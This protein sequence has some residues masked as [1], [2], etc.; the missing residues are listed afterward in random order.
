MQCNHAVKSALVISVLL[1]LSC[2]VVAQQAPTRAITEIADDL[3]WAQNNNHHSVFLVT[4]EGI[5]L[6]DPINADFS[7]W[8]KAELDD[9]FGVPVRYVVYSHHHW[10]HASGGAVFEDTAQFIGHKNMLGNL[11]LLPANTPLPADAA[12]LDANGNGQIEPAEASGNYEQSFSLYDANGDGM[13]SGAEATRGPLNEVRAPDVVYQ[14]RMTIVLGGKS[15]DL[16]HIGTI[17]HTDDMSVVLFPGER[18]V[19][20][21]DYISLG[22]L[23]F[24]TIF[25][26]SGA[27]TLDALL[28]SMRLVE[29]LDFD[30]A[31]PGHGVVGDKSDIA[32]YRHYLEELRDA[33][34]AG[35][36]AGRSVEE[37]QQSILMDPYRDWIAYEAW[38]PLNVVGMYNLLTED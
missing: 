29:M 10:D 7:A 34:A 22:R 11:A 19:F 20:F 3:Y 17:D 31:A 33:V 12:E 2:G 16:I 4:D 24:Q 21:V 23:P 30:V 1:P 5:I 27:G 36:A 8:L 25:R 18:A 32:A 35:I 26:G 38:R 6:V 28:N 37:L 9:R 15:A 14:D 13:I